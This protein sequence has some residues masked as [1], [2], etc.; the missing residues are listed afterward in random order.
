LNDHFDLLQELHPALWV[1][2]NGFLLSVFLRQIWQDLL[3][4]EHL[5]HKEAIVILTTPWHL[6]HFLLPKISINL[7]QLTHNITLSPY[8]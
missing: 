2:F 6:R 8:Y 3:L 5:L 4:S 1:I 7:E